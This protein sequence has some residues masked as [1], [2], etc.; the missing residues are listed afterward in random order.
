M[1]ELQAAPI[2]PISDTDIGVVSQPE[3]FSVKIL[4]SPLT[5][6]R[7]ERFTEDTSDVSFVS[8]DNKKLH[9]HKALLAVESLVFQKMCVEDVVSLA[10]MEVDWNAFCNAIALVYGKEVK[11]S[12]EELLE[13]YKTANAYDLASVK[14]AIIERIPKIRQDVVMQLFSVVLKT[15]RQMSVKKRMM[16]T[17]KDFLINHFDQISS[18]DLNLIPFDV[19]CDILQSD[20]LNVESE[21]SLFKAVISWV[22][23]NLECLS[24]SVRNIQDLLGHIR[25]GTISYQDLVKIVSG[26]FCNH[27]KFSTAL[28]TYHALNADIIQADLVQFTPRKYHSRPFLQVF[29]ALPDVRVSRT[30]RAITFSDLSLSDNQYPIAVYHSN[31]FTVF[32]FSVQFLSSAF[33]QSCSISNIRLRFRL[34]PLG[35]PPEEDSEEISLSL[36]HGISTPFI[37]NVAISGRDFQATAFSD[38]AHEDVQPFGYVTKR[39]KFSK[40][41][42]I[43]MS[44]TG[45]TTSARSNTLASRSHSQPPIGTATITFHHLE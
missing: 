44:I 17:C 24:L 42:S 31:E 29:P 2:S 35:C 37:C 4:P 11:L 23:A 15:E 5:A 40:P 20:K 19:M 27:K 25:Y 6:N 3:S 28:T 21:V 43:Y 22:Q 13:T 16:H 30:E 1:A 38:A 18:S 8:E 36:H 32:K 26:N 41:Y 7:Q 45:N 10:G 39:I 9:L 33:V 12:T 14:V 34:V